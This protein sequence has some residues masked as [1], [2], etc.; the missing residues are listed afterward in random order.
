MLDQFAEGI[1]ATRQL[2][3][4]MEEVRN[5]VQLKSRQAVDIND[6]LNVLKVEMASLREQKNNSDKEVCTVVYVCAAVM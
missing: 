3:Y 2:E 1:E 4:D 5:D 6:N